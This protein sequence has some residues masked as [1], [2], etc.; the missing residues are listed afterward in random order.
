MKIPT[1][2]SEVTAFKGHVPVTIKTVIDN[3]ILDQVH[4][5]IYL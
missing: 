1:P 2:K 4:T 3:T 5:F